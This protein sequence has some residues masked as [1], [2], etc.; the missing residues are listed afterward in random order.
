MKDR[1]S[2]LF[3]RVAR[4]ARASI[5]ILAAILAAFA[6][7]AWWE[8]RREYR[9]M[10]D[11]L[12]A[13]TLEIDRNIAI[14]EEAVA[15][16]RGVAAAGF[17]IVRLAPEDVATLSPERVAELAKFT[18]Y[19]LVRLQQGAVTAFIEGGFLAVVPDRSLRAEIASL[20]RIQEEIDEEMLAVNKSQEQLEGHMGSNLTIEEM[21]A[22]M[23]DPRNAGRTLIGSITEDEEARRALIM[24]SFFLGDLY[25]SELEEAI[26]LLEAARAQIERLEG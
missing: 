19:N 18:D 3:D 8:E 16:N 15:H 6:L 24:R 13:V 23:S 22:L 17:E 2:T 14:L 1:F 25:S 7:D 5:A 12:D 26:T 20:P 21:L 11:A 10:L 9:Q 4:M